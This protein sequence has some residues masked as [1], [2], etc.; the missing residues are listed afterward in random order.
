MRL[1][2]LFHHFSP[3]I[4]RMRGAVLKTKSTSRVQFQI[5]KITL[6]L[7]TLTQDLTH[8]GSHNGTLTSCLIR[9]REM[10]RRAEAP[11]SVRLER[12]MLGMDIE[13]N[14]RNKSQTQE[15]EET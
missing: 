9:G 12:G 14:I 3:R 5:D 10:V 2:A 6:H 15:R 7:T 13:I 1:S 4:Y 8:S 11:Y